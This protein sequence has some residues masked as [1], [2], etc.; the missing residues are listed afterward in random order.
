MTATPARIT[1]SF[2]VRELPSR[3]VGGRQLV[4]LCEPLEYRVGGAE[5]PEIIVVPC[6]FVTDFASIPFGVRNLFP[7]LGRWGRPAI[8]HDF[9]YRVRGETALTLD[10]LQAPAPGQ[11]AKDTPMLSAEEVT[12]WLNLTAARPEIN[13][14]AYSRAE[15][16]AIFREAME[17]VGVSAWR[18]FVMYRA[19][20]MGGGGGWG[21]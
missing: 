7:A 16:D 17:V 19:V 14:R 11:S 21:R 10:R 5:S 6:G 9:L 13:T 18:R 1:E 4:K 2:L 15:A 12:A 20:R 8:I 3:E